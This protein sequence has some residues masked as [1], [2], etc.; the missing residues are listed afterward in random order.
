MPRDHDDDQA[1][2]VEVEAMPCEWAD[3]DPGLPAF[4]LEAPE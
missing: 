4:D 1:D 2:E 3:T